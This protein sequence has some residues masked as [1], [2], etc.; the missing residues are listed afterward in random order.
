MTKI[1]NFYAGPGSGKSTT[2]A[3]LYA[4]MKTLGLSVELVTEFVKDVVWDKRGI[5][6]YDQPYFLGKQWKREAKL[7][8]KV[9]YIVTDS[10]LDMSAIY[11]MFYTGTDIF[12]D[13][14]SNLRALAYDHGVTTKNFFINR[15][16]PYVEAGRNETVEQARQVDNVVKK[17]LNSNVIFY[18][19]ITSDVDK[20]IPMILKT[21]GI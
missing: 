21:L 11:S 3:A 2:A 1:I 18:E 16:K 6:W 9:D 20:S 7:Y 8:G 13:Y 19:E 14:I 12:T 15:T 17:Y 10:P 4:K 5:N